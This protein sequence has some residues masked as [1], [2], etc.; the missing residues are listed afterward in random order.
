YA[1]WAG[2]RLPTE[3]EWE[4]AARGGLVGKP[5]CWGDAHQGQDGK[6]YANAHLG[7]FPK[8]DSGADGFAGLAPV[9][10]FPA[11]GYG[12]LDMSG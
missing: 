12:L 4:R 5:Y 1:R 7:A 11:N 6:G 10:R 8:A 3:A 9:G 2:K